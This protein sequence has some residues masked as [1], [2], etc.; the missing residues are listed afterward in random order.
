VLRRSVA[1]PALAA[2]LVLGAG[3]RRDAGP[4]AVG[5][6]APARHPTPAPR[7][8]Y[9]A[10]SDG[11]VSKAQVEAYLG[12]LE[13]LKRDESRTAAGARLAPG[14]P[15]DLVPPDIAAAKARGLNPAEYVWVKER[16]LEAEAAMLN[17]KLLAD[18]LALL[19]RTL[20][21]LRARRQA[22]PDE[23]SKKLL[24][25]QVTNFEAEAARTRR[26]AREKEPDAVRANMKTIEAF[27]ARLEAAGDVLDH[28][29][30]VL[31]RPSPAPAPAGR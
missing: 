1:R 2:L 23:G 14:D 20:G 18:Q 9:K 26:E 30:P 6:A 3:C 13:K 27:R 4:A 12:V 15:L 19:E 31:R 21:D 22:A 25:E 28:P 8:V 11:R 5:D 24:A 17:E 7:P 29:L 10:P 16:V